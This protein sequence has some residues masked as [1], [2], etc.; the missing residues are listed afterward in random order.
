ML[1]CWNACGP[2]D[3]D[4]PPFRKVQDKPRPF[5]CMP[6]FSSSLSKLQF[7]LQPLGLMLLYCFKGDFQKHHSAFAIARLS[8][9]LAS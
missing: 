2:Q 9:I 7:L 4:E 8:S 1:R 5:N 6:L 3:V